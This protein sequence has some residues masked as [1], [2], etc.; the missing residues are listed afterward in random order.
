ML[1]CPPSEEEIADA[2]CRLK[3]LDNTFLFNVVEDPLERANLKDREKELYD[4]IVAEWYGWNATM[5]PEV[6]ESFTESYTGGQLADHY[7]A[8]KPNGAPDIPVPPSR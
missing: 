1:S 3:I 8:Q 2:A 6:Q 4:G 7:G 5:L